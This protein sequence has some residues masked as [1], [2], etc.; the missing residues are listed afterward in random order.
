MTD[1]I[2]T[3]SV[4]CSD[5]S[6]AQRFRDA[7]DTLDATGFCVLSVTMTR[8]RDIAMHARSDRKHSR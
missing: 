8:P 5:K 2:F 4:E 7:A 1:T 3:F 6:D